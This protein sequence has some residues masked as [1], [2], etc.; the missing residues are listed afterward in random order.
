MIVLRSFG[1]SVVAIALAS[2][3]AQAQSTATVDQIGQAPKAAIAAIDQIGA[4]A[5][6]RTQPPTPIMPSRAQAAAEIDLS[7][8]RRP[9]QST[10][11][12]DD[13]ARV[14]NAGEAVTI[15]AAAAIASGAIAPVPDPE[16]EPE[17]DR[18]R[19]ARAQASMPR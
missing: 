2:G 17:L 12:P 7:V 5:R 9:A 16:S 15:D 18:E 8:R 14:L 1:L 4:G 19:A 11:D 13:I 3:I 10:V 6:E